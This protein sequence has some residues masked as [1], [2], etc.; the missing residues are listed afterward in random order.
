MHQRHKL[1]F[2]III[3]LKKEN[4]RPISLL[5]NLKTKISEQY[6]E[7]VLKVPYDGK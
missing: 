7:L 6:L 3:L 4:I 1:F 2:Y 5:S